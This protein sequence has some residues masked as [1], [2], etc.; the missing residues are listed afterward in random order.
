MLSSKLILRTKCV[1]LGNPGVGKSSLVQAFHSDGAQFPKTYAMTIHAEVCVKAVNVPDTNITV[2]LYLHDVGGHEVFT[3]FAPQ[4]AESGSTFVF[5][6]DV[7]NMESFK[8]ISS[9]WIPLAKKAKCGKGLHGVLIAHKIDQGSRRV[10]SMAQGEELAKS[11]GLAYFESSAA[12]NLEVDAPFFFLANAFSEQY[13]ETA[14][15]L[16]RAA[17]AL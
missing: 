5:V 12:S 15:E 3:E 6:Y 11:Q 16:T 14:R 10:I 9:K 4:Y 13:E 2:E 8:S 17:D 1:V 7:T